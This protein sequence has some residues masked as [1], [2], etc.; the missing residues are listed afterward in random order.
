[1]KKIGYGILALLGSILLIVIIALVFAG[2]FITPSFLVKQIES[3]INVRAHVESVN[4]NL[5][6]VLSGIEIEGI[7]LAPRDE[8][9]NK[10]TPLEERKLKP[11][12]L[13]E[14]GKADV[15]IS[16]L[17]LLT[18]TLKVNKIVLKKPEISLTMNEDG[19]N[20]LTSLFK[21]PKIV[22]GEKNPALSAEALAEKKAAL[23]EEEK[24]K[25]SAP[26]SGPFSIKD[27]PIAIKMGLVGI[28]EGNIQVNMRKT[29]QQ[30]LVQKLDLELKDIDIDGSDLG[31]HNN[32]NV[33]FDADVTI[34]GRNKKE[35]AK[36]LLD[37]EGKVTPFV[38]KTGLVNPKVN[39]EV[40]MKEDSFLS[41][42]AAFDAIAGELPAMNQA[43]LKLDKL[44]EKAELK[45]DV[46]FHVEYS[47]G[48]VT[49]LDEP[50]FPTKN[51][52][53]QITKGSYIVTTTNYHEMKMGMLYDEEESKKSL[54]SVDEKIKQAM[55]GQGDP[56]AIR[57]KIVGN[58]VKDDRLFIP[59]RTYGDIRNPNVELG[60]GLGS[61]TDLIGGAVKEAIK[62]K[63]SE[64]LKKLPGA[65]DALKGLGF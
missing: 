30:I 60:V 14:L 5:F 37:T 55:K 53:L 39:Y 12:G 10:G 3:A 24:E 22:N 54:A 6:N 20:N 33:N 11:K 45:K 34:I 57:N 9:A 23:E 56:K 21:T 46:S 41:G 31:S 43:G 28:Q 27:I 4:I 59:F 48:K 35:A 58:L 40:T 64:A 26:A 65:G 13:I 1:M 19:G 36:F 61:L 38:V 18:K 47:N 32:V 8:I 50:T 62:G 63:A 17:A 25:A 52:D 15:K 7:V 42:F 49:F 2:S 44:K 16:F 51:Y 29:G